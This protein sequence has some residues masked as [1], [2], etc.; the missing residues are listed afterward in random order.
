[1][2]KFAYEV[3]CGEEGCEQSAQFKIAAEWSDGSTRELKTYG[4][5]CEKHLESQFRRGLQKQ[6][7]C[8]LSEGETLSA[9]EIFHIESGRRDRD[10]VRM[11][12]LE[13]KF[14]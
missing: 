12:E 5:A 8:R 6:R 11:P 14:K 3:L 7:A 1:M 2:S 9:P 10:L 13:L 4:L